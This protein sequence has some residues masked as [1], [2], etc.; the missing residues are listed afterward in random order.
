[1]VPYVVAQ[2]R[3][4]PATCRGRATVTEWVVSKWK[5]VTPFSNS[6]EPGD[7]P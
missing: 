7:D 3:H 5:G 1:V 2:V 6:Y 4:R